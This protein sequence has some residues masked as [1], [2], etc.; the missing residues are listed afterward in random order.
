MEM[1]IKIVKVYTSIELINYFGKV[2][3]VSS[4]NE[5]QSSNN[6]DYRLAVYLNE[7]EWLKFYE[8]VK[9][10]HS[11]NPKFE[12]LNCD[13]YSTIELH[14]KYIRSNIPNL[15]LNF[16]N[17]EFNSILFSNSVYNG[18]LKFRK[19]LFYKNLSFENAIFKNYLEFFDC[20]FK[21][22]PNFY[23]SEFEDVL[24]L[25]KSTFEQNVLFTYTTFNRS[26]ILSRTEFKKG[27]DLSQAIIKDSVV[28]FG[29]KISNFQS[30]IAFLESDDNSYEDALY[31]NEIPTINKKETFRIIK[32]QLLSKNNVIDAIYFE[33][34]EKKA[35]WQLLRERKVSFLNASRASLFWNFISNDFKRSFWFAFW[36]IVGFSIF[37]F[38]F[39]VIATSKYEFDGNSNELDMFIPVFFE[40][41]NPVHSPDYLLQHGFNTNDLGLGYY[42]IDFLGRIAIGYGI[43]QFIQAFR[44]F[45]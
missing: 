25:T 27:I 18:K 30:K 36:F 4:E 34:L 21:K 12:F 24:T 16:A 38:Y 41:L 1:K 8:H 22:S 5:I 32:H 9:L 33:A 31:S 11:S 26:L 43:Y 37:L 15:S 13:F 35:H 42:L 45:K 44:K 14:G 7:G 23:K 2:I 29:T 28:L 17:C 10:N 40:F 20:K 19:C 6:F 39:S 3:T